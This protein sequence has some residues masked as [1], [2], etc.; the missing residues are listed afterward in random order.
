[1][2]S[3]LPVLWAHSFFLPPYD[4]EYSHWKRNVVY[5]KLGLSKGLYV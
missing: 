5:L 1:M 3:L 4:T 2:A